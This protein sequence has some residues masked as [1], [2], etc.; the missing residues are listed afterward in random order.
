M[1]YLNDKGKPVAANYYEGILQLRNPTKEVIRAVRNMVEG[2]DLIFT[3]KE[4]RVKGG[5][6]LFLSSQKI[7][8]VIA[9][10]L[11]KRFGG[12]IKI[13]KKLYGIDRQTSKNIYRVT[14][15]FR[16]PKFKVGDV[17]KAGNRLVKITKMGSKV[18]GIDTEKGKKL[19]FDYSKIN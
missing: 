13:S 11:Q 6:D 9:K 5:F 4:A 8:Q 18:F 3:A 1:E 10:N 17:V 19:S 7:M 14:V 16:L 12:E 15:L 2:N